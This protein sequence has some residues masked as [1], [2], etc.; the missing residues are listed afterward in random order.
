[1]FHT[2]NA[3][4]NTNNLMALQMEQLDPGHLM[5][6]AFN[7]T[8]NNNIRITDLVLTW[9]L[10]IPDDIDPADAAKLVLRKYASE[11]LE[12]RESTLQELI[13]HLKELSLFNKH[14]LSAFAKNRRKRQ[15]ASY[16][17]N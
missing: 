11:K 15:K 9:V 1:M 12:P 14:R 17:N 3:L 16:Y 5:R 13:R 2:T 7:G 8:L 10:R 6:D 4:S